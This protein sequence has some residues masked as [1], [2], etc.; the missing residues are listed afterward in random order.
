MVDRVEEALMLWNQ[1][2]VEA[3]K[4]EA[5]TFI[6]LREPEDTG[7]LMMDII[8]N[9]RQNGVIGSSVEYASMVEN[10]VGW[11]WKK[12]TAVDH[13]MEKCARHLDERFHDI[14][15][16]VYSQLPSWVHEELDGRV[17]FE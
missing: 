3:L 11:N 6:R 10:A 17:V 12:G 14:A 4:R 13:A 16:V 7:R 2:N 8:D 9:I 5:I 1:R 15:Q